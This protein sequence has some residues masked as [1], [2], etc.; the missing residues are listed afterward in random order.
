MH[1]R[2]PN[3]TMHEQLARI[4]VGP[5]LQYTNSWHAN[6]WAQPYNTR[7]AGMHLGRPDPT[8]QSSTASE[9]K[10]EQQANTRSS[11]PL[12]LS[13]AHSL[14]CEN[15]LL[16]QQNNN[17]AL[18]VILGYH[19]PF[20]VMLVYLGSIYN[21]F[22]LEIFTRLFNFLICIVLYAFLAGKRMRHVR[23]SATI[24]GIPW[25]GQGRG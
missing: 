13:Q 7:T 8:K 5:I 24:N 10:A 3:F 17:D 21:R 4:W 19:F 9:Q 1:L 16:H 25:E 6:A 14:C 2:G 12:R 20:S 11:A 22:Y 15:H 23:C 18:D